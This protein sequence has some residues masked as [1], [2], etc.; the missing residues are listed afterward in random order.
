MKSYEDEKTDLRTDWVLIQFIKSD[1]KLYLLGFLK[2]L[3]LNNYSVRLKCS[4]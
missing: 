4:V 3:C 2:T 1:R